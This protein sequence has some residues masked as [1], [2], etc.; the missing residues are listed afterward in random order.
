M[1]RG[2]QTLSDIVRGTNGLS[3]SQIKQALLLMI[4]HNYVNVY[5]QKDDESA[6]VVRPP[7]VLYES[8]VDVILQILR[9]VAYYKT[10]GSGATQLGYYSCSLVSEHIQPSIKR[11]LRGTN[12]QVYVNL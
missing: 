8:N 2:Q 5:T 7:T 4:Q 1:G 12:K 3:A 9:C 6:R 10:G 11:V